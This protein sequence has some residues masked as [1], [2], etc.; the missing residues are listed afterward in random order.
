MKRS[1]L[2]IIIDTLA[3]AVMLGMIATGIILRFTLP[4]GSGRV[5]SL[6]GMTRHQ[7]GDL[8]FWLALAAVAIVVLHLALHWTWVV[9]VVRRWLVGATPGLPSARLRAVAAVATVLIVCSAVA[10]F[11][12][13][14]VQSLDR[15]T[16]PPRRPTAE[17]Q[18]EGAGLRGSMT[19][20]ETAA[21]LGCSVEQV[22]QR[23]GLPASIPDSEHLGQIA[24]QRATTMQEMRKRLEPQFAEPK[25]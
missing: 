12:W 16:D 8:H 23:L 7:W 20:A 18:G 11:W 24:K 9:S 6:W 17:H 3:A 21:A 19:L 14:S 15:T 1:I 4:P 10:G 22:R 25:P 13:S 2:N 5:L